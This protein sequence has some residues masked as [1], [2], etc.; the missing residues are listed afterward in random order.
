MTIWLGL[1]AIGGV[2]ILIYELVVLLTWAF[3]SSGRRMPFSWRLFVWSW[4]AYF[5][6]VQ[7][8]CIS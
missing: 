1:S 3:P 8:R 2:I 5:R 6:W 4:A 7:G